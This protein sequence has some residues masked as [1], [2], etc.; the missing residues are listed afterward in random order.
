MNSKKEDRSSSGRTNLHYA[1]L[2]GNA[3]LA[4]SLI[5][6]GANPSAQDRDGWTPLHAAVQGHHTE[7]VKL[8]LEHGADVEL[9]DSN[10]NTPLFRAVFESRGRPEIVGLLRAA[11]ADPNHSNLHGVSPLQLSQTIA[12][13][14]VAKLFS[15]V[16]V[17]PVA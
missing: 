12:N 3:E 1:A 8:L 15:D 13:Y 11:G 6:A 5:Q 4:R 10:G 17:P 14:E 7:V 2:D 9:A 16:V